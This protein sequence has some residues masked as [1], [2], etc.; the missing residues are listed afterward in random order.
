MG[1]G[2]PGPLPEE[3]HERVAIVLMEMKLSVGLVTV[4]ISTERHGSADALSGCLVPHSRSR[5]YSAWLGTQ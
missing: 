4:W 5:A 2:D 1:G 3:V